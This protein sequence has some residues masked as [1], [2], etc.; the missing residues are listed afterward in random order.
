MMVNFQWFHALTLL[1]CRGAAGVH[2]VGGALTW[3]Q[4]A[5]PTF[6]GLQVLKIWTRPI[7]LLSQFAS[8]N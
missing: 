1:G 4:Q 2:R 5:G 3:A 7:L 8:C 6:A